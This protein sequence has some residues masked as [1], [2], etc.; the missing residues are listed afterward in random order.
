VRA[1]SSLLDHN[2]YLDKL[3]QVKDVISHSS[4]SNKADLINQL[5]S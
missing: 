2:T 4:L 3:A 5:D 1:G